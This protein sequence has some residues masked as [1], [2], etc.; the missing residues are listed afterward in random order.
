MR[1]I[2]SWWSRL[3]GTSRSGRP[4]ELLFVRHVEQ[5]CTAVIIVGW[6]GG[7][8]AANVSLT[9]T[10]GQTCLLWHF[11]NAALFRRSFFLFNDSLCI[12]FIRTVLF[13][14]SCILPSQFISCAIINRIPS[15]VLCASSIGF[16]S[17]RPTSTLRLP[18]VRSV[19]VMRRVQWVFSKAPRSLSQAN[20]TWHRLK[21]FRF[22]TPI[23]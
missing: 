14:P 20:I 21:K 9:T 10:Y 18:F 3:R 17:L 12:K 22:Y 7:E 1:S 15:H 19:Q 4:L 23:P 2:A 8:R 13:K 6:C 16:H 11:R 5:A